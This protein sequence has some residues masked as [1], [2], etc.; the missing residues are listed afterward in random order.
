MSVYELLRPALICLDPETAHGLAIAALK[1]GLLPAAPAGDPRLACKV[2]GMRFPNPV[3][4]AAGFDKNAEVADAMLAQG[5]GFVET[6]SLTPRPQAGNAHPR[7]F[8][9]AA[10]RAVINRMGFN[11]A[12][13]AAALALLQGRAQRGGIVGVNI[14]ANRD[15]TDRAG[16]Y[17]AGIETFWPVAS[18]FAANISSPNTPGLRELQTADRLADLL[19]RLVASRD[20]LAKETGL[21]RPIFVKLAPDLSEGEIGE[22]AAVIAASRVEGAIVSNTT[23]SRQ[24]VENSPFCDEAG[25]LSGRPLFARSTAVLARFR[26][27]L[28]NKVLIGAGGVE[29]A[30]TARAK[31][32]AGADLVQLYT[33]MI[34]RGPR[35]AQEISAGLAA[36][37]D[38]EGAP[39]PT[40]WKGRRAGEWAA[41]KI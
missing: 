30:A 19:A 40:V 25:G 21:A 11:N 6:G 16:D 22:I 2:A 41:K 31:I 32:E 39:S 38:A 17:V 9:L 28:P 26:L 10:E 7:L 4:L 15:S 8:R 20:R 14:G 5:F 3:G 34:F 23:L 33:A 13:H 12:G 27:A 24:G 18:Y 1:S 37:L 36:M 35:I 29:D